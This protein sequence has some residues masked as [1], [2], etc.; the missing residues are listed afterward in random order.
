MRPEITISFWELQVF[1]REA[2]RKSENNIIV[3]SQYCN[4]QVKDLKIIL[5]PKDVDPQEKEL[6]TVLDLEDICSIKAI[7]HWPGKY[8]EVHL[9]LREDRWV[10]ITT[11]IPILANDFLDEVHLK[12]GTV[13]KPTLKLPE[14]TEKV[15]CEVDI[16]DDVV[17][18]N[19][20]CM[21]KGDG[22]IDNRTIYFTSNKEEIGILRK[23]A[24][25]INELIENN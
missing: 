19:L 17:S 18:L 12:T 2:Y 8:D 16:Q 3:D 21:D 20:E 13:K 24:K 7:S 23:I 9:K 6:F 25:A 5:Y 1:L 22:W 10:V 15:E 11:A 4:F 14:G